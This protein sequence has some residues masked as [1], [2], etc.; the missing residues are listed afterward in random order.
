MTGINHAVGGVVFTGIFASFWNVNVFASIDYFLI[1]L[2]ASVLPDIDH[3]R[4]LIGKMFYPIA[5]YLDRHFKHRTITHC[6]I[7]LIAICLLTAFIESIFF[8]HH[9]Y[10][11]ILF[12]G[13]LSHFI[14]DMVT[15]QGIPLFYP[16]YRNPCVIFGN[17]AFRLKTNNRQSEL[18]V[19]AIFILLGI[20][21]MDLFKNGFWTTYNRS[22]G[23]LK[24]LHQESNNTDK[25]L[26]V[27]YHFTRNNNDYKGTGTLIFSK[28]NEAIIFDSTIY[29]LE[30]NNPL[31]KI[32]YVKPIKTNKNKIVQEISFFA[33]SL[34]SLQNLLKNKII[35]GTIQSSKPVQIFEKNIRK[36]TSLIKLEYSYNPELSIIAD[37][38]S[39]NIRKQLTLKLERLNQNNSHH[40]IKIA[41]LKM[42]K[43]IQIKLK[44]KVLETFDS[45]EKNRLQNEIIEL[46]RKIKQQEASL[47]N[48]QQ[49]QVLLK[50]IE[51]LQQQLKYNDI[52]FSG[53]LEWFYL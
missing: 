27:D 48:Y 16:F 3:T 34:D 1:A 44:E 14:F 25:L 31:L 21:C 42:S 22:F 52:S 43:Q 23:T 37:T 2:F 45:Y 33:I 46:E 17:P 26:N 39:E 53:V 32:L 18:V 47:N 10:T 29:H 40:N 9:H 30:K 20:S 41:E 24:H 28:D 15:I 12:F 8:T 7:F 19:L 4:S 35:S 49:D 13:I 51:L 6:L 5:K 11:L 50:E 36:N 38:T